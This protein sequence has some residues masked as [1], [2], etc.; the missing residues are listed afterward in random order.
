MSAQ[1]APSCTVNDS[2]SSATTPPKRTPTSSTLSSAMRYPAAGPSR[3]SVKQK[4]TKECG[5]RHRTATTALGPGPHEHDPQL[6]VGLDA[7][8]RAEHHALE[9]GLH[10]VHR[11]LGLVGDALGQ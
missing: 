6:V 4:R 2:P 8:A 5:G 10:Q 3:R 11:D 9:R 1:I 7:A